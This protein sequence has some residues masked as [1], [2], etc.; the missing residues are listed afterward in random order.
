MGT[1]V[2][3]SIPVKNIKEYARKVIALPPLPEYIIKKGPYIHEVAK[4]MVVYEFDKG[5]IAEA[6]EIIRK[7]L[8]AFRSIP[9]FT[10]SA[11]ILARNKEGKEYGIDL[12]TR[13]IS[14]PFFQNAQIFE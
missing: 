8:D 4:I 14:K 13:K 10:L 7:H 9:G 12:E 2:S 1:K 11:P 3:F 5:K 6:W